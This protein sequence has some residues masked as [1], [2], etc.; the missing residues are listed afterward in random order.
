MYFNPTL[1][2]GTKRRFLLNHHSDPHAHGTNL[3]F[4]KI[5]PMLGSWH[6]LTAH[7]RGTTPPVVLTPHTGGIPNQWDVFPCW[8]Y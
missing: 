2:V 7:A 5:K 8:W 6:K 1:M 4:L 3:G